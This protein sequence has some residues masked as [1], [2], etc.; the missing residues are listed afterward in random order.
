[1][2][3]AH[4]IEGVVLERLDDIGIEGRAAPGGAEGAVAHVAPGPAGDLAELGRMELAEAEAVEF[5]VGGEGDV[6]DVEVQAHADR[7]GGDEVVDVAVL[8]QLDLGVARARRERAEH[9]RGAAALAP[10]QLGDGVDLLGREGDDG[11]AARQARDLLLAGER[12]LREARTADHVHARDQRLDQRAHG[13]GADEQRFLAAALVQQPI[14]EDV[15]A[16]EVGG[17]LDLVDRDEGEV[18][19]ARHRLD[20]RDP[21]ARLV[22]LDLLLAGDER[23][24][25]LAGLVDDLLVD[26]AGEKPQRQPDHAALVTEHALDREMGLA[27]V[28][29]P[30]HGGDAAGTSL[31]GKRAAQHR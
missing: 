2:Q 16:V 1:M 25:V 10:D 26:L 7:V 17:E 21:V 8:E 9:D 29:R 14:G 15:A 30:E 12:E 3:D 19:V 23:D 28:R 13:R 27:G 5:L 20:G 22:R 6:V 11:G 24:V 31:R 18:E 4:R